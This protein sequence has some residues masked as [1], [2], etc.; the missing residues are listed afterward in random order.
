MVSE[1][2][3]THAKFREFIESRKGV[4]A[5]LMGVMGSLTQDITPDTRPYLRAAVR[6]G[7]RNL[8][9]VHKCANFESAVT[10]DRCDDDKKSPHSFISIKS[11][12]SVYLETDTDPSDLSCYAGGEVET[13]NCDLPSASIMSETWPVFPDLICSHI[14]SP[15]SLQA[16]QK[17]S[18]WTG[19]FQV[20]D[21]R[22]HPVLDHDTN[23]PMQQ[24]LA[25]QTTTSNLAAEFTVP[26]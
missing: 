5:V 16:M 21:T 2:E 6:K 17:D 8:S 24:G 19:P 22:Y 20:S 4:E 11:S 13:T 9:Q 25:F 10:T 18:H 12:P 7:L 3:A 1:C 15:A 14:N 26:H 23:W